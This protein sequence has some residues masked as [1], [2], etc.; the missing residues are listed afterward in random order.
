MARSEIR[1]TAAVRLRVSVRTIR[2]SLYDID[3]RTEQSLLSRAPC[4]F[5]AVQP[6]RSVSRKELRQLKGAVG[7]NELEFT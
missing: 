7:N 2:V 6:R 5:D 4:V 3:V 1:G